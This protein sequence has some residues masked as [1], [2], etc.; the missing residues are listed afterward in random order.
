MTIMTGFESIQSGW[1][2]CGRSCWLLN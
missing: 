1:L 2:T